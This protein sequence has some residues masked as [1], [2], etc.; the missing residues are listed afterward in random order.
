VQ[1]SGLS[2]TVL[3]PSWLATNARRDW[4]EQI[5]TRGRVGI[6]YPDAQVNPIHIDDIAEVAVDL[7]TRDEHRGRML[8]LTGPESVPQ[9]SLVETLAEVLGR[10][11][12]VDELTRDEAMEQRP[13]WLPAPVLDA[14]L[15]AA[16]AAVDVPAAVTNAVERVT[17]HPSRTFRDWALANR[18]DFR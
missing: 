10:P 15:D 6:A 11:I 2:H 16:A 18:A 14:L 4:G 13:P 12:D 17:G 8:V 3:Y 1:D 5:S 7:L 9:R